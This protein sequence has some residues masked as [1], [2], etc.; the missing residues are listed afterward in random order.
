MSLRADAE[1]KRD[2]G[3]VV[4]D[5][6]ILPEGLDTSGVHA[7]PVLDAF[8][9][10]QG[11]AGLVDGWTVLKR[12]AA[13]SLLVRIL[14][15]DLVLNAHIMPKEEAEK[16]AER[17]L[18]FFPSPSRFFSNTPVAEEG[19][20]DAEDT[21]TGT[22]KSITEAMF[23]TGIVAVGGGRIGMFWVKDDG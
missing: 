3:D 12:T 16:L 23:D 7:G 22:W 11:Y 1:R 14:A 4:V 13:K 20:G 21:W 19:D 8:V 17:F 18:A 2:C 15:R 6:R 9:A 5:L 10:A